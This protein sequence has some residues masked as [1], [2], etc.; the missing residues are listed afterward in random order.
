MAKS[1]K[2][3]QKDGKMQEKEDKMSKRSP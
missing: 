1:I 3:G 2:T